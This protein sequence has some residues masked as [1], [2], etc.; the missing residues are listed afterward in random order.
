MSVDA[1][2]V[3]IREGFGLV[4]AALIPLLVVAAIVG[5]GIALLA[6][7]LGLRDA[8]VAQIARAVAVVAVVALTIEGVAA[9]AVAYA[10]ESWTLGLTGHPEDEDELGDELEDEDASDR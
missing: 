7:H 10:R 1:L 4:I 8:A 5:I 2:G 9:A 3:A 6:G